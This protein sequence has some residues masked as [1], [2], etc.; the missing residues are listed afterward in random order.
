MGPEQDGHTHVYHI[1]NNRQDLPYDIERYA[2]APIQY[3][4]DYDERPIRGSGMQYR[5]DT[6]YNP[7]N[8]TTEYRDE[9]EKGGS[10]A[11]DI[12]YGEPRVYSNIHREHSNP[13]VTKV[14]AY[15]PR[16]THVEYYEP[17]P[18][19]QIVHEHV[20]EVIR[21]PVREIIREPVREVIR[22][23]V[24]EVM[25]EPV[26]GIMREPV[27]GIMREPVGGIMREP[28]GGIIREASEEYEDVPVRVRKNK[29]NKVHMDL[30]S[31]PLCAT[32]NIISKSQCCE[33]VDAFHAFGFNKRKSLYT[34]LTTKL[35]K[36]K[37]EP[38]QQ[39]IA[40]PVV[41]SPDIFTI[42][43]VADYNLVWTK[44][45]MVNLCENHSGYKLELCPYSPDS[46][47]QYF[48]WDKSGA[49]FLSDNSTNDR[50]LA[51]E[52]PYAQT[53]HEGLGLLLNDFSRRNVYQRWEIK[54]VKQY[55]ENEFAAMLPKAECGYDYDQSVLEH[56][57][58]HA[59]AAFKDKSLQNKK[60]FNRC[61][62]HKI[63]GSNSEFA[64]STGA[65]SM[66]RDPFKTGGDLGHDEHCHAGEKRIA[67]GRSYTVKH[68]NAPTCRQEEKTGGSCRI[69]TGGCIF[70]TLNKDCIP[71]GNPEN[72]NC[73]R[74]QLRDSGCRRSSK[75]PISAR[76]D[77]YGESRDYAERRGSG[78]NLQV[79]RRD[80][81]NARNN[82][83]Y[84]QENFDDR[85]NT[86]PNRRRHDNNEDFGGARVG[87]VEDVGY[88]DGN[89]PRMELE[90]RGQPDMN[91]FEKPLSIGSN[92]SSEINRNRSGSHGSRKSKHSEERKKDSEEFDQKSGF[93]N[94][95]KEPAYYQSLMDC[96]ELAKYH[97][98]LNAIRTA[99]Y[100]SVDQ[101]GDKN[102]QHSPKNL[103]KVENS[104]T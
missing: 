101:K 13:R 16:E 7:T 36:K 40:M 84:P 11:Q 32:F 42:H 62:G 45:N 65:K 15:P 8:Y 50:T 64:R 41:E 56:V 14:I 61:K 30:M 52:L 72:L 18:P 33:A 66:S 67:F 80:S 27:G 58:F 94:K 96:P 55:S 28:A 74:V 71:G 23:P 75:R 10:Y 24:R 37:N 48:V 81:F 102:T 87:F 2:N 76:N 83:N 100:D 70:N 35:L 93:N 53:Y 19:R 47:D 91:D 3:G 22:E 25:R 97:E 26:R 29:R 95:H 68:K 104:S 9:Y 99:Q 90:V 4:S 20:R 85:I 6:C 21:E 59:N 98:K 5:K 73:S 38:S 92:K 79:P 77:Y 17:S 12:R 82:M 31:F 51:V 34:W 1:G 54:M 63:G 49:L 86:M 57:N 88:S 69:H 103:I 44:G 46:R 89:Y 78:R 39:W 60:N 43:C